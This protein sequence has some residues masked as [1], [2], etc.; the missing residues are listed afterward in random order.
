VIRTPRR[1]AVP[2]VTSD[3]LPTVLDV[4]GLPASARPLD[5][6]SLRRLLVDGTLAARPQPIGF[7]R[8]P[9]QRERG[10]PRWID[11]DLARGTTPTTR[12]PAIDFLNYRHPVARTEDFGGEAAWTDNRF[13]LYV[14]EA[15]EAGGK[16]G[17]KRKGRAAG[18]GVQLFDLLAD[19]REERDVSADHPE[20]A[21]RMLRELHAW[22]RSVELS[23][24]GADY[25]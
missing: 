18:S 8:Y 1:S 9:V 23:L 14:P 24:T 11:A 19:P 12:N 17:A 6:I 2:A 7:W 16:A 25:R 13:K 3:I 20:V 15:T 21:A 5:G 22:Q 10:N 4:L